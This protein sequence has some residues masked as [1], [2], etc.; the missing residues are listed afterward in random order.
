MRVLE[1]SWFRRSWHKLLSTISIVLA[2][3]N[4]TSVRLD[5]P[6]ERN[7]SVELRG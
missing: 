3:V 6:A 5:L 7:V 1:D 4:G 2:Q